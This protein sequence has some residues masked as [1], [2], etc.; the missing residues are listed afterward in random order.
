MNDPQYQMAEDAAFAL[1]GGADP[2]SLVPSSPPV[3]L[4][5]TLAPFLIIYDGKEEPVVSGAVLNGKVPKLPP[6]LLD[7]VKRKGEHMV[8][9]QPQPDVREALVIKNRKETI[10]ILS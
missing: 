1:S 7:Y 3:E 4:T 6:G 9:W 2:K 5:Q 8:T 10:Y